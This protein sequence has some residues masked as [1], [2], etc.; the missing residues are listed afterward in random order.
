MTSIDYTALIGL[1]ALSTASRDSLCLPVFTCPVLLLR[2]RYRG[3]PSIVMSGNPVR[4]WAVELSSYGRPI[5]IGQAIIFLSCGF[6]Y[7]LSI[8]LLFFS[9][10][11]SGRRLD[12]YHTSTHGVAL[13]RI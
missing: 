10:N 3:V 1:I 2:R 8:C 12:V 13:V 5:V 9:P 7:L 11:L 4:R 6:F